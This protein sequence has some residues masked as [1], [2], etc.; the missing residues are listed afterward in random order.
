VD[1]SKDSRDFSFG[2]SFLHLPASEARIMLKKI[3]QA[4]RWTRDDFEPPR[5]KEFSSEQKEDVL[6]VN[7]QLL[8]SQD[9]TINPKSL[10]FQFLNM[11]TKL[12]KRAFRKKSSQ[13]PFPHRAHQEEYKDVMSSYA[14]EGEPSHYGDYSICSPSMPTIDNF[15]QPIFQH[16]LGPNEFSYAL[17]SPRYPLVDPNYRAYVDHI[18]DKEK[19]QH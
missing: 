13:L 10:D 5:K 16:I 15:S 18:D 19:L 12:S 11:F 17:H 6:T 8:Q 7:S 3:S 9:S 1:L 14:I 2:G 4:T